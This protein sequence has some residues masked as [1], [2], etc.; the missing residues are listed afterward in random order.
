MCINFI[1]RTMI[2]PFLKRKKVPKF[3]FQFGQQ[4]KLVL[5]M[6]LSICISR[7]MLLSD[8]RFIIFRFFYFDQWKLTLILS[9]YTP[10]LSMIKSCPDRLGHEIRNNCFIYGESISNQRIEAWFYWWRKPGYQKKATD[11]SQATDNFF[12]NSC[13]ISIFF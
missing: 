7:L 11:H 12:F 3:Y 6:L 8:F 1:G 4:T 13:P 2:K 9:P 10:E 5:Y